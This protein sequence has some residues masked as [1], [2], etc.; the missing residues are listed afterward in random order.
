MDAHE[1]G[2]YHPVENMNARDAVNAFG[3]D[4]DILL[5]CWP[6]ATRAA[7]EAC[8]AWGDKPIVFIGEFTD[9]SK[10]HLGGCATDEF[11]SSFKLLQ[12]FFSYKGN[13]LEKACIGTLL[14]G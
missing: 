1:A 11:F 10:N 7:V 13:M 6:T 12:E 9:Y 14:N 4:H 2:V 8:R 5:M 3:S